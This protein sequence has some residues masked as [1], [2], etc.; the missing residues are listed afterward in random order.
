MD[1]QKWNPTTWLARFSP[2]WLTADAAK[3]DNE[4][5]DVLLARMACGGRC[6]ARLAKMACLMGSDSLTACNVATAVK[7]N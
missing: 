4:I 2:D 5:E 1:A 6:V 3:V 7:D